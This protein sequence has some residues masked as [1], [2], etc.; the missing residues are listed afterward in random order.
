MYKLF[1]SPHLDDI[2]FSLGSL[3]ETISQNTNII[4]ATVFTK[5][6][7]EKLEKMTGELYTYG[8]YKK[9]L[10]ED[11]KSMKLLKNTTVIYFD[12]EDEIFRNGVSRLKMELKI[13][14]KI[15]NILER[16]SVN[17][18]YLPLGIGYH[19]DHILVNNSIY[20]LNLSGYKILYYYD[21]PYCN[22]KLNLITRLSDYG[23]FNEYFNLNMI[24][25]YYND[26]IYS[27]LNC[28]VKTIKILFLLGKYL[29]NFIFRQFKNRYNISNFKINRIKKYNLMTQ[30]DSQIEPIF[31]N[32]INLMNT[33]IKNNKEYLIH[34]TKYNK[35]NYNIIYYL[36]LTYFLYF[37]YFNYL[38]RFFCFIF[39]I[40]SI[41]S[42]LKTN[43]KKIK[44]TV[45][46]TI[47][48]PVYNEGS[49]LELLINNLDFNKD[50]EYIFINDN[51]NDNSLS[52]LTHFQKKYKFKL[53]NRYSK[54]GFVAGVL[55]DGLKCSKFIKEKNIN[56]IFIGVINGDSYVKKES[57]NNIKSI[58]EDNKIDI[59]NLNNVSKDISSMI[60]YLANLEKKFKN[61]LFR[62]IDISLNNGYIINYNKLKKANLW[63]EKEIT[64]DLNLTI[65]LKNNNCVFYQSDIKIY[66]NLPLNFRELLN[67]KYRWVKG[68]LENRIRY[69][70]NNIFEL[71]VNIYY[72]Y[73]IYF[74]LSFILD[75]NF[76]NILYTQITIILTES[77]LYLYFVEKNQNFFIYSIFQFLFSIY[78]YF[79]YFLL[80]LQNNK[81]NYLF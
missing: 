5:E 21:Y 75:I 69:Y 38:I 60:Q 27:S 62:N 23:I 81:W 37:N 35:I 3:I 26:P 63:N 13:S 16:Y 79:K 67:Q 44:R 18:I 29:F 71:I 32:R 43:I 76:N 6:N 80:I 65:K 24:I 15:N 58:L 33:L 55:N 39:I 48:I 30:Y 40:K 34:F 78:F 68:D 11:N 49:N 51:S 74:I 20:H 42:P 8:N 4:I 46:L 64:E 17:E 61:E 14:Y 50:I 28:F 57:I 56:N 31:K 25:S 36:L 10:I 41:F 70:P 7:K 19:T 47:L 9:R 73:P 53:I 77:I 1:I 22:N 52:I 59:I 2:I 54:R 45:K 66:D 72:I 12:L